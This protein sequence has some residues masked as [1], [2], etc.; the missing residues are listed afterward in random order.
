MKVERASQQL[1]CFG[2]WH[3]RACGWGCPPPQGCSD[4]GGAPPGFDEPT[5]SA[6][7][8]GP[9]TQPLD[10]TPSHTHTLA[11]IK[12]NWTGD[13]AAEWDARLKQGGPALVS[14]L[15]QRGGVKE[16]LAAAL[17]AGLGLTG[18]T[19]AQASACFWDGRALGMAGRRAAGRPRAKRVAS[20]R[21]T[22]GAFPALLTLAPCLPARLH[23]VPCLT[24]LYRRPSPPPHT[25]APPAAQGGAR[26]AGG[27]AHGLPPQHQRP[28]GLQKGR[29]GGQATEGFVLLLC[30][31]GG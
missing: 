21:C 16:R 24:P 3:A 31:G 25:L 10:P 1:C 20:A 4:S 28:R 9:L 7:P 6:N 11:A 12:V 8:H 23:T 5:P 22:F 29:G 17:C 27:G 30:G 15:L 2:R 19:A 14:S 18:R 26:C 13:D